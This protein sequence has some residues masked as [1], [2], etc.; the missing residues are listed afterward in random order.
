MR[1][2]AI[3]PFVLASTLAAQGT[4]EV[5]GTVRDST[6]KPIP[7]GDCCEMPIIS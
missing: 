5:N 4:S 3:A 6:G 1:I 7:A 2:L